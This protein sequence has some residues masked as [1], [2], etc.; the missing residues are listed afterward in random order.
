MTRLFSTL[1]CI[2]LST[3]FAY[4]QSQS[5]AILPIADYLQRLNEGRKIRGRGTTLQD[6]NPIVSEVELRATI[7]ED[8]LDEVKFHVTPF[9]WGERD[10]LRNI[11]KIERELL[12]ASLR[13]QA[14]DAAFELWISILDLR[15]AKAE[16]ALLEKNIQISDHLIKAMASNS[17]ELVS[18]PDTYIGALSGHQ[19]LIHRLREAKAQIESLEAALG[20]MLGE[21]RISLNFDR[22]VSLGEIRDDIVANF[23]TVGQTEDL[24]KSLLAERATAE[25]ELE[26]MKERKMLNFF[27]LGTSFTPD[28]SSR[29]IELGLGVD[30]PVGTHPA[31]MLELQ[32]KKLVA[33]NDAEA[34]RLARQKELKRLSTKILDRLNE[35]DS[36]QVSESEKKMQSIDSAIAKTYGRGS[37]VALK[38]Q[39]AIEKYRL[40]KL[41]SVASLYEDYLSLSLLSGRLTDQGQPLLKE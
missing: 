34:A 23:L 18:R 1:L 5:R 3:S 29:A 32:R 16:S 28:G 41:E 9:A 27:T 20:A 13:S 14:Q 39:A 31:Q 25:V 38:S 26:T 8:Q 4:A 22:L 15:A 30:I 35:L 2:G 40:E 17:T 11:S 6:Q 7:K 24:L 19:E 36:E 10:K 33:E 37:L 21:N 12:T